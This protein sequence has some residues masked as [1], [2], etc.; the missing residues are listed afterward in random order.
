MKGAWLPILLLATQVTESDRA[1]LDALRAV[2]ADVRIEGDETWID[3]NRSVTD[4][5][6]RKVEGI[7]SLTALRILGGNPTDSFVASLSSCPRLWLLVVKSDRLTDLAAERVS[8]LPGIK[9]L[10]FMGAKLSRKGLKALAQAPK[11]E[12]L[13]LHGARLQPDS[14][15]SLKGAAHLIDLTL[16]LEYPKGE[17]EGLRRALP[18]VRIK[19]F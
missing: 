11:L 4:V 1:K 5:Q 19:Q 14:I 15:A 3:F 18:K 8:K 2:G 17:V 12:Q 7:Q 16:P 9:K 10:D 13:Y 6:L